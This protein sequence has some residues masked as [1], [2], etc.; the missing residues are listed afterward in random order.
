MDPEDDFFD[1]GDDVLGDGDTDNEFGVEEDEDD[2]PD[3]FP[4]ESFSM[5]SF[6]SMD[7]LGVIR[8]LRHD[9]FDRVMDIV[10][11]TMCGDTVLV[12]L[13]AFD[14]KQDRLIDSLLQDSE[15]VLKDI[16][17]VYA[18]AGGEDMTLQDD[19]V[20]YLC[21]QRSATKRIPLSLRDDE[22]SPLHPKYNPERAKT[23][24]PVCCLPL[25]AK[26]K[27]KE[28]DKKS[29][30]EEEMFECPVCWNDVPKSKTFALGCGHRYCV[31][32]WRGYLVERIKATGN[33]F[34]VCSHC[35]AKGCRCPVPDSVFARFVSDPAL[36]K[37]YVRSGL[38]Q[39]IQVDPHFKWCPYPGCDNVMYVET[40]SNTDPVTCSNC[41]HT[42]C[43]HCSD[44]EIGD[45]RPCLCEQ[46][47]KWMEKA[48]DESENLKWLEANTKRCPKCNAPIFKD[49][50]C[51]HMTCNKQLG[52][53]GYEFCWLCRGPWSQHGAQT[54]GYYQCNKYE[55]SAAKKIDDQAEKSRA[56]L[57]YYMFF[58]HRYDSHKMACKTAQ[59]Q[60]REL[61]QRQQEIMA[62]FHVQATD[63]RF[64]NDTLA[65]L[66]QFRRALQF[67][68]AFGYFIDRKSP[69]L[70]LFQ[71]LQENL[72]RFTNHLAELY[73]MRLTKIDD[74]YRWKEDII[75]CVRVTT[76]FLDNFSRG[77]AT[78][79]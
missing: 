40:L 22:S 16:G 59:K 55:K 62:H 12:C 25:P 73:E 30:D 9:K 17:V 76:K 47:R 1:D 74:F 49:G 14:W 26:G 61:P 37:R 27:G 36:L 32:C 58:Y 43:F 72:E 11:E 39:F 66:V 5:P 54:G 56:E 10:G 13:R 65:S 70:P 4:S 24:C 71:H 3:P 2:G 53:C 48:T 28:E 33:E 19:Y 38:Q 60:L 6:A 18:E 63:T 57:D 20:C 46:M 50:G 31:D 78:G 44:P 68:Y 7:E 52:G 41:G 51:M 15:K 64:L 79:L 42:Y 67:S 75:N 34:T 45:H 29:A 77:V 21:G 69:T 8:R 35:M 23:L